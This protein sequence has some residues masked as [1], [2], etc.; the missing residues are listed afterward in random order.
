MI[1]HQGKL[2]SFLDFECLTWGCPTEDFMRLLL[3]NAEQHIFFRERYTL[4]LLKT[5]LRQT[6][7]SKQ[8]WFYGMDVFV[9]Q[10]YRKKLKHR[11]FLKTLGLYR[12]NHLYRKIRAVIEKELS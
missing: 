9:L 6:H 5:I 4:K 10:K 3:T 11:N 12:C 2:S 7:F 1:F 8:E